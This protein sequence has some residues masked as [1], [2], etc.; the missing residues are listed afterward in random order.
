MNEFG[1]CVI[2]LAERLQTEVFNKQLYTEDFIQK[3]RELSDTDCCCCIS[4][5]TV[6]AQLLTA[7]QSGSLE[8]GV[9]YLVSLL[10]LRFTPLC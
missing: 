1:V 10:I 4:L 3:V 2:L 7:N 5:L 8:P 6:K 9:E